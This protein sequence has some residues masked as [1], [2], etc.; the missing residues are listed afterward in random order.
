MVHHPSVA[1]R[2]HES[3]VR[4]EV[5]NRMKGIVRGKIWVEDRAEP[6]VLELHGNAWPDLAGCLLKFTNPQNASRMRILIRFIPLNAAASATSRRR[7]KFVCLTGR[8]K[9]PST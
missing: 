8:C 1:F 2:I 3:V 7:E 9:Q 4:G 5:D 6:V